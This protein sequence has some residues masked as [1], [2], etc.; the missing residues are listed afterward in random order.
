MPQ[1]QP[2]PKE[3]VSKVDGAAASMGGIAGDSVLYA[4]PIEPFSALEAWLS[5]GAVVGEQAIK[6]H[7]TP[8]KNKPRVI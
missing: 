6:N 5:C 4:E 1:N 7:V 2:R 3:A 8:N